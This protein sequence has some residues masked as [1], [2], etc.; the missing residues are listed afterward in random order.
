VNGPCL[1]NPVAKDCS[2][3]E[4]HTRPDK[5]LG[6]NQTPPPVPPVLTG[7]YMPGIEIIGEWVDE[8]QNMPEPTQESD[9]D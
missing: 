1:H 5:I 8:A 6:K 4:R 2:I 7:Q 9:C 3:C